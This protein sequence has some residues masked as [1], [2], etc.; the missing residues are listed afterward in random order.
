MITMPEASASQNHTVNESN[1]TGNTS[2]S[3]RQDH[4]TRKRVISKSVLGLISLFMLVPILIVLLSWTQPVADIWGHM[5]EYVLP[6]VLKNTAILLLMVTV[7][8]GTIGTVLDCVT[9]R[10][11]FHGQRFFSWARM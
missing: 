6:Q 4:A 2:K 11:C 1:E 10:Y 5:R 3:I 7:I 8:S 9:S